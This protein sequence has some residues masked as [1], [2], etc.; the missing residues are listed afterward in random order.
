MYVDIYIY[1]YIHIYMYY[2]NMK[3]RDIGRIV[4]VVRAILCLIVSPVIIERYG[5]K[6]LR[7]FFLFLGELTLFLIIIVESTH[8]VDLIA[9]LT[10]R[11]S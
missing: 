7:F 6:R 1:I 5:K 11:T 3:A 8:K 4:D 2:G 9:P 10:V